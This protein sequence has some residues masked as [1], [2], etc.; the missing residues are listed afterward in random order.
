MYTVYSDLL[1]KRSQLNKEIFDRIYTEQQERDQKLH[2]ELP[3]IKFPI[4]E[5]TPP[6]DVDRVM[7]LLKQLS[8][9]HVLLNFLIE[10]KTTE[11]NFYSIITNGNMN[12]YP[13][14]QDAYNSI[15]ASKS[16]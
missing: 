1:I 8:Q 10:K 3:N 13:T 12:D 16:V 4:S 15:V 11:Q 9:Q 5:N 6:Q 7:S 14:K 2:A